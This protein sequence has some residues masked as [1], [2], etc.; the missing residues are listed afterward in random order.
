MGSVAGIILPFFLQAV[1]L[2]S[3][4]TQLPYEYYSLPFC[5]PSEITYKAENLGMYLLMRMLPSNRQAAP[6]ELFR[7]G[8]AIGSVLSSKLRR[9]CSISLYILAVCKPGCWCILEGRQL[10]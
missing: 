9:A 10:T 5:Q 4:R 8:K 2:T 6:W 1:K 7:G 3:S